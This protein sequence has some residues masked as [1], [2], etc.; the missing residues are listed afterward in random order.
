MSGFKS[1][2]HQLGLSQSQLKDLLNERLQRNY[3]RHTISRWENNKQP[4]PQ[5]VTIELDALLKR[6]PQETRVIT[7]ANQKGGV[8]KTTSALNIAFSLTRLNY[9]VLLIDADPQASATSA[10]VGD[11]IVDIY[12]N[13]RTLEA[14]LLKDVAFSEVI[15][16]KGTELSSGRCLPFSF[17]PSHIDLAEVD[18][19]RE[20]G[21]EGLL[22]E[23][24]GSV[25]ADYD[26][27]VI[28]SPPHLGFLTWMALTAAHVVY[29]P[30]RTEP[31][32]VMGV[33]LV[34]D[35]IS[36]VH[37]RSNPRLRIGGIIPTQFSPTQYVDIGIVTHLINVLRNRAPVLE[38]VPS[39][40]AYS[41]AAWESK[42]PAE[43]TPRNAAVRPY[44]RLA[45]A[46]SR[47]TSPV[48]ATDVLS[49][50]I[51]PE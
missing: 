47:G 38:P 34:L 48:L 9:R 31:Y 30:V 29:I 17:A 15:L 6:A 7:F 12:R 13:G 2:R 36:K 24:I 37:R 45:E 41:N 21:T 40:T 16:P 23:A 20:P 25:K 43:L 28:D 26:F 32:D 14:S 44:I 50:N 42:I 27:I 22:R 51:S 49:T 11:D 1:I 35:T 18:I 8:G 5:D 39:S 4:V 3:D 46:I 33:N 19:R 10:L